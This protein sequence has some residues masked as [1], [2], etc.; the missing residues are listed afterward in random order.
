M[1]MLDRMRRHRNWLKWSLVLVCLA[2]VVFYIPDFLGTR[3]VDPALS[4][5]IA[6]VGDREIS[7]EMFRRAYQGQLQAYRSAYG[8]KLN[9]QLLRQLGIDQQVLQ[10]MVD[11]QAAVAEAERLGIR[12]GDEEV[13]QRIL[14]LPVFQENGTFIGEQR[15]LMMLS[16]QNPP[17]S[18]AQ[19]EQ[20]M[21][22]AI[23][24][25]KLRTALTEWV[26]VPSADLEQEY[27]RRNDKVKLAVVSLPIDSFRPDV[28][29]SDAEVA[30]HFD[31]NKEDFRTPAKRK[32]RYVLVDVD[33]IQARVVVTPA[34]VER[35]YNENISQYSE[36][37]QIRASHILVRTEGKD[38]AAARSQAEGLLAKAR[39][40][41]DFAALAKSSSEDESTAARG[42]D[43]DFF[44]RGR[45]V[46]EF[47]DAAFQLEV[48]Q[49]SDLVRSP[50]GYHVIKLTDKKPGAVRS[51]DEVRAQITEAI[52]FERAQAQAGTLAETLRAQLRRPGDLD[53]VAAANGLTVQES[54]FF[55]QN[56]PIVGL[57]ASPDVSAQIFTLSD[58]EVA[59]PLP[60]PRGYAFA[61][62]SGKAE[63]SLPAFDEVR[64]RVRSAVI[65]TRAT[66]MARQKAAELAPRLKAA[67]NFDAAAKA[68]GFQSETTDLITRDTPLADLGP[69]PAVLDAAFALPVGGVS[70]P[71]ETPLGTAI[72]K[73]VEKQQATP[74]QFTADRDRFRE[75]LVA[76]RRNQYFSAYMV[77][78]KQTLRVQINRE[79]L[80]R[81][82]G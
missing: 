5:I 1:T 45:M 59:G 54:E 82:V 6:T 60:T 10:Q 20:S 22:E 8:D 76:D 13:R 12:V 9:D 55:A 77:R 63:S 21:R 7:G 38:E 26:T 37:D 25:D 66:E 19:F 23:M 43:L 3:A 56:E 73:V 68:G 74:E 71:L 72:I 69:A 29:V 33:A 65:A 41:A 80:Q 61:A 18:P 70:D 40:G 39:G 51:I 14:T 30:A 34:E 27:R 17:V 53:T 31:A 36:P 16:S 28:T 52:A 4:N 75:Q 49:L 2:F 57:G 64:E 24:L 50:F 47:E 48:G 62:V 46:Q 15:Y 35:S 42:G 81:I 79:V 78:A 44:S 58:E 11:E 67:S 32:I